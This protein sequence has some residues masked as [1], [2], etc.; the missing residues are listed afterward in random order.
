MTEAELIQQAQK[1]VTSCFTQLVVLYQPK[2]HSYL[3]ARCQNPSDADDVLQETF[4]NAHRYIKTYDD[5]WAFSTWLFTIAKRQLSRLPA[6][7]HVP[8]D[9]VNEPHTEQDPV[10]D[11]IWPLIKHHLGDTV[12]DLLW[13]F[14]VEGL[15]VKDMAL[16]MNQSTSW[17]KTN[18]HRGKMKLSNVPAIQQLMGK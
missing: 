8:I 7:P 15:S 2:V 14:Y 9:A 11:N 1:G 5:R 12:H 6:S 3:M 18:L 17:V 13:F 4:I 16:I 10:E